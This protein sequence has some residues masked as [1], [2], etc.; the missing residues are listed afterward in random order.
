MRKLFIITFMRL[1]WPAIGFAIKESCD[2]IWKT[3]SKSHS[4]RHWEQDWLFRS[5]I[6]FQQNNGK[7]ILSSLTM[8]WQL[9]QY[10]LVV[11]G[12]IINAEIPHYQHFDFVLP[13]F[14]AQHKMCIFMAPSILYFEV[15]TPKELQILG[16]TL[17]GL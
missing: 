17:K 7:N 11:I 2:F 16:Q 12:Q 1:L 10:C 4:A 9:P 13:E 3:I 5:T 14:N 6:V 15:N 8:Q